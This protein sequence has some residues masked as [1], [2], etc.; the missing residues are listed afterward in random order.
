MPD[1]QRETYARHAWQGADEVEDWIYAATEE[2]AARSYVEVPTE[3]AG[4]VR[5]F[6]DGSWGAW[7]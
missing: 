3:K 1:S 2:W 7:D 4:T 5:I 6:T